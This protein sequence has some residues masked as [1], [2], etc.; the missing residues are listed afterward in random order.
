MSADH[1]ADW[2]APGEA[3]RTILAGIARLGAVERPLLDALGSV[4]AED[5]VS[6]VDLPP[7]DNSA[8]DGFAVRA[9]WG[10][11]RPSGS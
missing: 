10:R 6:P 9:P 11:E 3:L 5:V 8:M 4:L 1:A 7:W 2:L